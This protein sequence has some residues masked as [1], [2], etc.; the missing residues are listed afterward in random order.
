M[1]QSYQLLPGGCQA[2][3]GTV[4][5]VCCHL[6]RS[7]YATHTHPLFLPASPSPRTLDGGGANAFPSGVVGLGSWEGA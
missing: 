7:N 1:A 6:S 2:E 4:E 3:E 5:P